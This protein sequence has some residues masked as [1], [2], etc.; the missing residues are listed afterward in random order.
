MEI[1]CACKHNYNYSDKFNITQRN[2]NSFPGEQR[3]Q[4]LFSMAIKNEDLMDDVF[5][6]TLQLENKKNERRQRN[7][8]RKFYIYLSL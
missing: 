5:S 7:R 1:I 3:K 4:V 8:G 2:K 6:Q